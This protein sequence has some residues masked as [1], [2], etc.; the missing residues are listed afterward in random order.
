MNTFLV[1]SCRPSIM[2]SSRLYQACYSFLIII[3]ATIFRGRSAFKNYIKNTLECFDKNISPSGAEF[4][5]LTVWT[6]P[7]AESLTSKIVHI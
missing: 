6:G 4:R 1:T 3:F 5:R 2:N 7:L